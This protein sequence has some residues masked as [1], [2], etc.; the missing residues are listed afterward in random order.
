[1]NLTV[2]LR[3]RGEEDEVAPE[4]DLLAAAPLLLSRLV[5]LRTATH[6][7]RASSIPPVGLGSSAEELSIALNQERKK[8]G[9]E[10]KKKKKGKRERRERII[11]YLI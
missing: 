5:W 6:S 2:V 10:E 8:S 7:S 4:E 11:D 3:P 9:G 1:M